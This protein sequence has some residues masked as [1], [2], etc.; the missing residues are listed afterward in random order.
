M[1]G[2]KGALDNASELKEYAPPTIPEFKA[3]MSRV[4]GG[5]EPM[6]MQGISAAGES[7]RIADLFIA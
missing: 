3:E 1:C 7:R 5:L 6:G 4:N 2:R